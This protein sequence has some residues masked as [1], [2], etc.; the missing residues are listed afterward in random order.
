[1]RALDG[2][3]AEG[4][5]EIGTVRA[6][7]TET[8]RTGAQPDDPREAEL[9]ALR[10]R[11]AAVEQALG[12]PARPGHPAPPPLLAVTRRVAALERQA[13]IVP[14]L[15]PLPRFGARTAVV[16]GEAA[17]ISR[18]AAWLEHGQALIAAALLVA[19]LAWLLRPAA[20]GVRPEHPAVATATSPAALTSAAGDCVYADATGVPG[21]GCGAVPPAR[22]VQCPLPGGETGQADQPGS[23]DWGRRERAC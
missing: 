8:S 15:V 3:I 7:A 18:R 13:G 6:S 2:G 19:L 12:L 11:L 1:M 16:T 23:F 20:G 17:V 22:D 14:G 5:S 9:A 21:Q 10:A 4:S